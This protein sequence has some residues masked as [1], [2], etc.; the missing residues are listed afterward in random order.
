MRSFLESFDFDVD[1]LIILALLFYWSA[2]FII[3]L[4][5]Y[6]VYTI[7]TLSLCTVYFV[8]YS[9]KNYLD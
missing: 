3:A 2:V 7:T 5:N 1:L 9:Y 4:I 8:Y 6:P